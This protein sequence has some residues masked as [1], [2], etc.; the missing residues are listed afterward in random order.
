MRH[1]LA[2]VVLLFAVEASAVETR[3]TY[4][5]VGFSEDGA[6]F[7][8]KKYDYNVGWAFSVRDLEDGTQKERV[9]FV[10]QEEEAA[11]KKLRR[12][13]KLVDGVA[14]KSPDGRWVVL[15]A[16]DGK[17]LDVLVMDK[18]RIGRFKD[19][20]LKEDK[21]KKT[22]GT[23]LLKKAVWSPDGVF[24]VAIVQLTSPEGWEEDEVYSW[25][26]RSWKV[27]WFRDEPTA[28]AKAEPEGTEK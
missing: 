6:T 28:G 9:P 10:D 26:F 5:F 27:K 18:P 22:L 1:L 12:K 21:A 19:I 23:G 15:G 3:I 16:E 17:Y 14:T 2:A 4:E 11:L 20:P 25:R 13:Y 24:V 8:V 7:L